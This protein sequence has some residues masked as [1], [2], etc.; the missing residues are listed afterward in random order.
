MGRSWSYPLACGP[1][2]WRHILRDQLEVSEAQF[3]ACVREGVVPGRAAQ[4][5]PLDSV[6]AEVVHLLLSRVGLTE[7]EVATMSRERAVARL[8]QYWT[9]GH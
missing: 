5:Q 6:P 8:T 2:L 1:A 4:Q 9:D 3:W 7:A